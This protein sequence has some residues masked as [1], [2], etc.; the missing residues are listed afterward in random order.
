M[1]IEFLCS[2]R[3]RQLAG[4]LV[5]ASQKVGS[6]L[7]YEQSS[8]LWAITQLGGIRILYIKCQQVHSNK[9]MNGAG[10]PSGRPGSV[11]LNLSVAKYETPN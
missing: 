5:L 7:T 4:K 3:R 9:P 6:F 1:S 2:F 8:C 11:Q 10:S